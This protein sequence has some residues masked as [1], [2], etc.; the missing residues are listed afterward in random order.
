MSRKLIFLLPLFF[1]FFVPA[2]PGHNNKLAVQSISPANIEK[3]KPSILQS[4]LPRKI[5][6][7]QSQKSKRSVLKKSVSVPLDTLRVTSKFGLRTHPIL[8]RKSFHNGV[9]L[10]AKLN[11]RV[12]A[13]SDGIVTY[14]GT[15]GALGNAVYLSHPKLK[16][17][18]IYG[19]LNKV[20]VRQGQVVTAGNVIGYAGTT[21]RSTGVHLHLTVKDQKTGVNLEPVRYFAKSTSIARAITPNPSSL[22]A[23]ASMQSK[24]ETLLNKTQPSL[25]PSISLDLIAKLELAIQQ[26][27]ERAASLKRLYA[28]G[29]VVRN[30]YL[31]AERSLI[32]LRQQLDVARG[33][34]NQT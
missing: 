4:P 19:H 1:L 33:G 15:R 21:G 18:S 27:N 17:T 12:K 30:K 6:R 2:S 10:A 31:D 5:V 9:D 25:N 11:D 29:V 23:I 32:Q 13:I 20:A 22:L 24:T 34:T 28:E 7:S 8:K 16:V 3:T 14:S 26:A